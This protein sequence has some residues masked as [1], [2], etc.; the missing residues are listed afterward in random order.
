M[1]TS[2]VDSLIMA[3]CLLLPHPLHLPLS[4]SLSLPQPWLLSQPLALPLASNVI[5]DRVNVNVNMNV[6]VNVVLTVDYPCVLI[7]QH[8]LTGQ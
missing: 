1:S 4:F 6:N 7:I 8:W 5:L 2:T 3:L